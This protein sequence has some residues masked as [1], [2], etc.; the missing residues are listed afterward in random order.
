V[1]I[2][3][4]YIGYFSAV[5]GATATIYFIGVFF[6]NLQNSIEEIG[7]SVVEVKADVSDVKTKVE[8]IDWRVRDLTTIQEKQGSFNRSIDQSYKEHL[9]KSKDQLNQSQD[10]IDEYT[11]YLELQI[12]NEKKKSF[13]D[14][15]SQTIEYSI[16]KEKI[17]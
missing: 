13:I 4:K 11:K 5:V 9:K 16:K 8:S 17:K 7:N 2:F 3:L 10:L 6:A 14:S 12:E 15:V 1:K